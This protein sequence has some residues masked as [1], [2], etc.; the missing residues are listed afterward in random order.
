MKGDNK[1]LGFKGVDI[2]VLLEGFENAY[3]MEWLET[4]Y[5][6]SSIE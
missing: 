4:S 3:G 1:S 5:E 6:K 2:S